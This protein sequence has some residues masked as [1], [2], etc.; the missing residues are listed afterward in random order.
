MLQYVLALCLCFKV[1]IVI[2]FLEPRYAK[3]KVFYLEIRVKPGL[4]KVTRIRIVFE[5]FS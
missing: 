5:A 4:L 2:V 3:L 1:C